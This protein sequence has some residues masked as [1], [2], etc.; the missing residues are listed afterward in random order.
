MCRLRMTRREGMKMEMGKEELTLTS[1]DHLPAH[2]SLQ[3]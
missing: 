2:C 3:H 1:V